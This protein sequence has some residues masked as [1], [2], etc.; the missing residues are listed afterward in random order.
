MGGKNMINTTLEY[1]RDYRKKNA[2]ITLLKKKLP[3]PGSYLTRVLDFTP[4]LSLF[5]CYIMKCGVCMSMRQ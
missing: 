3:K 4:R 5:Y 1:T 2:F